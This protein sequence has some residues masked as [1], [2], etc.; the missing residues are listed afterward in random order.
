MQKVADA[1]GIEWRDE[2]KRNGARH[3]KALK[4]VEDMLDKRLIEAQAKEKQQDRAAK[5]PSSPEPAVA[6]TAPTKT[7]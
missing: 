5:A 7:Q 2:A 1:F 4:H 6:P 3:A